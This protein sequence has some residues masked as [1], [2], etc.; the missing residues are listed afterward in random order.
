MEN[1]TVMR[2]ECEIKGF[3]FFFNIVSFLF[4]DSNGPDKSEISEINQK[5]CQFNDRQITLSGILTLPTSV[6][7]TCHIILSYRN[8]ILDIVPISSTYS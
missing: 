1:L 2:W 4:Q 5:I 8:A 3:L 6:Y 7:L